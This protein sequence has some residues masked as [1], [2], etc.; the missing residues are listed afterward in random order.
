[1]LRRLLA[2]DARTPCLLVDVA[3]P[4]SGAKAVVGQCPGTAAE[5]GASC[6]FRRACGVLLVCFCR[7]AKFEANGGWHGSRWQAKPEKYDA[8]KVVC[9]KCNA[10]GHWSK[11]CKSS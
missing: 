5:E 10:V 11:N 3:G 1:M 8:S 4:A 7:Q 2:P 9:W 6:W